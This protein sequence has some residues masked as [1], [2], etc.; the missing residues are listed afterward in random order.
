MTYH[1]IKP[2]KPW[3]D[4][5]GKPIQAHG[6]SVFWNK[7]EGQIDFF[8]ASYCTND[9]QQKGVSDTGQSACSSQQESFAMGR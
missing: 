7:V 6:F 8:Y 4:T 3:L 9:R 1:S 5:D 2:G